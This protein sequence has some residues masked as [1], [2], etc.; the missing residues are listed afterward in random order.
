VELYLPKFLIS[1]L[2]GGDWSPSRYVQFSLYKKLQILMAGWAQC[3]F[4]YGKQQISHPTGR[5]IQVVRFSDTLCLI[6]RTQT[7]KYEES[8]KTIK[9]V[10]Y[11]GIN[12]TKSPASVAGKV[13]EPRLMSQFERELEALCVGVFLQSRRRMCQYSSAYIV[14]AIT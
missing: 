8:L 6:G 5:G 10:E 12:S 14:A 3:R 4:V 13:S 7:P 2:V 1:V 9:A 11:S